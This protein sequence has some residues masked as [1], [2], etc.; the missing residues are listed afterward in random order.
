MFCSSC[1][2]SETSNAQERPNIIF[3]IV[4]D[5]EFI[6]YGC[7][8]GHVLTPNIDRIAETGVLFTRG[9]TSTSVCTPTRY[10]VL[11]GKYASRAASLRTIGKQPPD[12]SSFVSWNT[13]LE[14]GEYNIA[15]RNARVS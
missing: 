6:E 14:K 4:D 13:V 15:S 9:F 8:G 7:Y 5:S 1:S 11:T 3:I 12:L 10:T 2:T